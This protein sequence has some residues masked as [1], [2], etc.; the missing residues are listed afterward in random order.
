MAGPSFQLDSF[1]ALCAAKA[2]ST[3]EQKRL[4][5][6]IAGSAVFVSVVNIIATCWSNQNAQRNLL[7]LDNRAM[8]ERAKE[9]LLENQKRA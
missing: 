2:M 6:I 3:P 4:E 1:C 9:P 5:R 7:A 8:K